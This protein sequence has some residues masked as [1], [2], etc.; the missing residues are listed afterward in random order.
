MKCKIKRY[1]PAVTEPPLQFVE[2]DEFEIKEPTGFEKPDDKNELRYQ[3]LRDQCYEMG[4]RF[5]FYSKSDTD[6]FDFDV[7]VH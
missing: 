7:V 5:R 3:L 4:Y 2:L 1:D 6:G